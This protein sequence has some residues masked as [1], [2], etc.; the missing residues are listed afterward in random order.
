MTMLD[1]I[2]IED[3]A[4]ES[5]GNWRDFESFAWDRLPDLDRPED[6]SLVYTHNRDS[7]LLALSN[8]AAIRKALE[9][10]SKADDPDV[11]FESHSHW[12]VGHVDGFSIRVY[13]DNEITDAFKSYHELVERLADYPV[14]DEEAYGRSE[15]EAT[16]TNIAEAAWR[17]KREYELPDGWESAVFSW[18]RDHN[19]SGIENRD[20]R[21]GYPE[22]DNLRA[23]FVALNYPR[24]E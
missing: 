8:V 12:A 1:E 20:D 7:A 9:P 18:F 3:A 2:T 14:L 6:W 17:L 21:G 15:Y 10:F 4:Q 5:A 11:V 22:E 13:R 23:A 16:L 19:Q 24:L